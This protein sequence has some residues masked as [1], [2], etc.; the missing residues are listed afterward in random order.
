MPDDVPVVV[1]EK[2]GWAEIVINRP[3]RRNAIIPPVSNAIREALQ[4]LEQRD[5]IACVIL[6]GEGGYFCSGVDL[7]ALQADPPPPWRGEQG[8]SW[9]DLHIALFGFPKPVIGAFEN[10]GINAGSALALACDVLIAGET[11]FLQVGEI[12]QGAMMPMNAAWFKI[13]ATE[14]VMARM[15]FY[16]DRVPGPELVKLGLAAESVADDLVLERCRELAARIAGFPQGASRNIKLNIIA[17]RGIENPQAFFRQPQSNAL[18][19]AGMV[20]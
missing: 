3:E 18:L 19:S 11:A 8:S 16:G 5:E 12:Q 13:K 7:K 2:A 15:A 17:Q 9:R 20:R 6:R 1:A 10:Y 14:Q 4:V